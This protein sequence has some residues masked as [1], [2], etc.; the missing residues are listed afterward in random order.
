MP[1]KK[2]NPVMTGRCRR[3]AKR[4]RAGA[5]VVA[6]ALLASGGAASAALPPQYQRANELAAVVEAATRALDAPVD[7]VEYVSPDL[8]R[9]RAG[10]CAQEVSVV[11]EPATD[12]PS[13]GP[14]RFETRV[15]EPA[16]R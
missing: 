15:G 13:A 9:A 16:C 12:H 11:D 5:Q 1:Q 2:D 4:L 8:Y 6:L 7:A 3:E 14:R 10:A